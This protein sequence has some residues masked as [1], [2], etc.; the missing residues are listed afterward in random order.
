MCAEHRARETNRRRAPRDATARRA[1]GRSVR[2]ARA[3]VTACACAMVMR[4]MRRTSVTTDGANEGVK[5]T[6]ATARDVCVYSPATAARARDALPR[7]ASTWEGS[8]SIAV[9]G[10]ASESAVELASIAGGLEGDATRV[11]V[12]VVERLE[13][14]GTDENNPRFPV[15]YL[16]NLAREK[17]VSELGATWV[18]VHDIDFECFVPDATKF[19]ADVSAVLQPGKRHA[20]VVPAFEVHSEWSRRMN[21]KRDGILSRRRRVFEPVNDGEA[22]IAH[23]GAPRTDDAFP[24]SFP[25]SFYA[26][27]V[28]RDMDRPFTR[29]G[30]KPLNITFPYSTKERLHNL[31]RERRLADGFQTQYFDGHRPSNYSRWFENS[32]EDHYRIAAHRHPWYYEPYVVMRADMAIPFDESF[33]TYGFNKVE[34]AHELAAAGFAFFVTKHAHTVHTNVHSTRAMANL[35]GKDLLRCLNHPAGS[36]DYRIARIGHSCIPAFLRRM[37]CAYGFNLGHLQFGGDPRASPPEDLLF[38]LAS[39]DNIVCFGG[40]V[41][42]QEES[43]RTPASVTIRGGRFVNVTERSS[44]RRRKRGHC[45][46][47][48]GNILDLRT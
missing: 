21:S 10:G 7:L 47:F 22:A 2:R 14:Y 3:L 4:T 27:L 12:T 17:C 13:E 40:C 36:K 45:E 33:V 25:T 20:L 18:L 15:N 9:M 32:T 31:V 1:M 43:P 11:V 8:V 41:T 37:E 19:L 35:R 16:R 30:I 39:D 34:Y 48:D 38:R 46:R 42:D 29:N 26:Q 44:T 6:A 23:F 28:E 24:T 5:A